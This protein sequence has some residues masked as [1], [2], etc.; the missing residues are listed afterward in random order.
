MDK[1]LLTIPAAAVVL[2]LSPSKVY[3]MVQK[4]EIE[5]VRIGRAVRIDYVALERFIE[6][7]RRCR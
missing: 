4:G 1:R 3:S 2:S 7:N 5:S 6:E